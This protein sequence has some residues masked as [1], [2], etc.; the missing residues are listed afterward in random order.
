[1]TRSAEHAIATWQETQKRR[2]ASAFADRVADGLTASGGIVLVNAM[3]G[4]GIG[5][6][7]GRIGVTLGGSVL[8]GGLALIMRARR[9]HK[10]VP[11]P[12]FSAVA[13]QQAYG[14]VRADATHAA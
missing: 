11:R 14:I 6:P 1:M 10:P 13:R 2:A 9:T 3:C 8:A 4:L 7:T 5:L 12:V